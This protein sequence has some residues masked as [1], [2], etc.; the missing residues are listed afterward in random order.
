MNIQSRAKTATFMLA[1]MSNSQ[2]IKNST[3][4][5]NTI[6]TIIVSIAY[7]QYTTGFPGIVP[8]PFLK[9]QT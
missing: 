2:F 3:P 4:I 6:P 7:S 8:Y 5:V 9:V 1:G